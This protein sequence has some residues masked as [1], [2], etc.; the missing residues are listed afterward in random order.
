MF[1]N[2]EEK[3][4]QEEVD[5]DPMFTDGVRLFNHI[6]NE[7][8]YGR[9][10]EEISKLSQMDRMLYE[11][12]DFFFAGTK[13]FKKKDPIEQ[14][15]DGDVGHDISEANEE[16]RKEWEEKLAVQ[17][18]PHYD[19]A[20]NYIVEQPLDD[21]GVYPTVSE[22]EDNFKVL[23]VD[24]TGMTGQYV[25]LGYSPPRDKY[26]FC[27]NFAP[28]MSMIRAYKREE[29]FKWLNSD[30]RNTE[31][32]R[33]LNRIIVS[34]REDYVHD[35][36]IRNAWSEN[37]RVKARI[38]SELKMRSEDQDEETIRQ[39]QWKNFEKKPGKF[40]SQGRLIRSYGSKWHRDRSRAYQKLIFTYQR[41]QEIYK[42]IDKRKVYFST[43]N[44]ERIYR[45]LEREVN[46]SVD[47]K[48]LQEV[49]GLISDKCDDLNK[50]HRTR[51]WK[52]WGIKARQRGLRGNYY[53]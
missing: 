51:I 44:S 11:G 39:H 15:L 48:Q 36:E 28:N 20:M 34:I 13:V 46:R 4:Y 43:D 32:L 19:D 27:G 22:P 38:E 25:A 53:G 47:I 45:T 6:N 37:A 50:T 17:I 29:R 24:F 23:S 18:D 42:N 35:K 30:I 7:L 16:E 9:Q 21:V 52:V 3:E 33:D 14:A 31:S 2:D 49:H 10:M 26:K 5:Y 12:Q 8:M 1:L 40:M 41:W